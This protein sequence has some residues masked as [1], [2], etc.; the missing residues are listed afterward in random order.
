MNRRM[1]MKKRGKKAFLTILLLALSSITIC[2]KMLCLSLTASAEQAVAEGNTEEAAENNENKR[3]HTNLP[4]EIKKDGFYEYYVTTDVFT[5]EPYAVITNYTGTESVVTIPDSFS[6]VTVRNINEAFEENEFLMEATVPKSVRTLW[7]TFSGCKNLRKVILNEGIEMLVGAFSNCEQLCDINFPGSLTDVGKASFENTAW[8]SQYDTTDIIYAGHICLGFRGYMLYRENMLQDWAVTIQEGTRIIASDAFDGSGITEVYMPDSVETICYDAFRNCSR[9]RKIR[10]SEN[11]KYIGDYAFGHLDD[12]TSLTEVILPDS[13]EYIGDGAFSDNVN[14]ITI[15]EPVNL[16][17][18]GGGAFSNTK[19]DKTRPTICYI[20]KVLYNCRSFHNEDEIRK[21]TVS[22]SPGCFTDII[23][24]PTFTSI[25]IPDSVQTIGYSAFYGCY[26]LSEVRLPNKLKRIEESTFENCHALS[27]IN[28]P[29]TIEAIGSQAFDNCHAL[30]EI[31]LPK[32][33]KKIGGFAFRGA[34]NIRKLD[35]PK[36]VKYIHENAFYRCGHLD[37]VSFSE[38]LTYIGTKAF[39]GT[40][41]TEVEIPNSVTFLG[42][43]AFAYEVSWVMMDYPMDDKMPNFKIRGYNDSAAELYA[44]ENGLIFESLG[45]YKAVE[46]VKSDVGQ[47]GQSGF[48]DNDSG[49]NALSTVGDVIACGGVAIV[50]G[51]GILFC[52]P[53]TRRKI[54]KIFAKIGDE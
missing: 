39:S 44:V 37:T 16:K 3:I 43:Q 24:I 1:K 14:L 11:L 35:I 25:A 46:N 32:S 41:L 42:E 12:C 5:E 23:N 36:G 31:N 7:G 50:V 34:E 8:I 29:D 9:L 51:S 49:E 4:V 6:G 53:Q 27:V 26:A 10:F 2:N 40:S 28:F 52:I 48:D 19:W 30:T 18:V 38:G 13:L 17:Y 33:L 45:T 15:T 21:D 20:G 54:M 47:M 22:I